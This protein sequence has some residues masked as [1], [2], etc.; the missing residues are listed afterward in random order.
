MGVEMKIRTL[1]KNFAL[2]KTERYLSFKSR[3][4]QKG[5]AI[6]EVVPI[7][8]IF[9]T[10]MGFTIGFYGISQRMILHS[11]SAR[12]YGFELI[13]Q[14]ANI[15]YLRDVNGGDGNSYHITQHRYFAVRDSK[16]TG[17]TFDAAKMNIDFRNRGPAT[18]PNPDAH[19]TSAY[20]DISRQR[21]NDR[22][23]FETV[24]I[25]VGHGICLTAGCG[26]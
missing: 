23:Y 3:D 22:H 5:M 13:R 16:S 26:E 17:N 1:I 12:A 4:Q 20:Q 6:L 25:K 7:I 14:R 18:S 9:V 24:W 11:I 15:T 2:L 21:R 8:F 19:N 10:L